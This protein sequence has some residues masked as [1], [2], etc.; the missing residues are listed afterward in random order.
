MDER[1]LKECGCHIYAACT[2]LKD[3][4]PSSENIPL[5][6]LSKH[7]IVKTLLASSALPGVFGTVNMN[8]RQYSDGGILDN[9]PILPLS[10]EGCTEAIIVYLGKE[11][12]CH[13]RPA[14]MSVREIRP[15]ESLG[16]FITG[17]LDFSPQ[18]AARRM[19]LG[20]KDSAEQIANGL[21]W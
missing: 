2:A 9:V 21:L 3:G 11:Q 1:A 8:R 19:T 13:I 4:I 5:N 17:V 7:D 16:N 14:N 6:G 10:K 15:S 12:H 20:Y 18:G